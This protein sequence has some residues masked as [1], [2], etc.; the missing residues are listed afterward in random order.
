LW[1]LTITGAPAVTTIAQAQ[2]EAVR[3]FNRFYTRRIGVLQEGLLDS[4]WSLTEVRVMYEVAHRPGVAAAEL[5]T[6]LGLDRGYLSRILRRFEDEGLLARETGADARRRHLRLTAKGKRTFAPLDK[7][8][9]RQVDALLG[10][11][12]A[13]G[14]QRLL[15]ALQTVERTLVP[16]TQPKSEAIL[17][18][19]RPGDIGWVVQRHGELY[20]REYGYDER[21]EALVADIV[22]RFVERFDPARER[23]WIAELDGERVGS[24]FLVAQSKTIAK[25]RLLLVEP[26]ARGLG[27]GRRLVTECIAFAR[28]AGYRK[29]VLWTQGELDAARHLYAEAGFRKTDESRHDSFGRQGLVAETWELKL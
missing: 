11:L 16:A 6:D 7:R 1:L 27:L 10:A 15:S 20:V 9:Q 17:R 3:R 8:S 2:I 24:I 13:D 25:L 22:A 4:P 5:A 23:C 14:R 26:A 29:V 19:H 12:D 18:G 21:F 28:E